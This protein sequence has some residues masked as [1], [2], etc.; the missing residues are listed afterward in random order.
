[1]RSITPTANQPTIL[2]PFNS[3]RDIVYK[4]LLNETLLLTKKIREFVLR[5][6]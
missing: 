1:M 3:N 6:N 2:H 5:T 4:V